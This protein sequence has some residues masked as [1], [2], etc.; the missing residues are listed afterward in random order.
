M[1][2]RIFLQRSLLAGVLVWLAFVQPALS[3]QNV[4]EADTV[5]KNGF[6]YTANAIRL[7]AQAFAVRDG[8]FVKIGSNMIV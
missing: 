3:A 8:K 7:Q 6:I 1:R 5:Y 4:A 2:D